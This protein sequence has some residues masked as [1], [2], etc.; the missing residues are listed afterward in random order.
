V[1]LLGPSSVDVVGLQVSTPKP[2][3]GLPNWN[4]PNYTEENYD[5]VAIMLLTNGAS[6]SPLH[7]STEFVFNPYC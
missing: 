1:V 7:E 2:V 6:L 5:L 3:V 4:R